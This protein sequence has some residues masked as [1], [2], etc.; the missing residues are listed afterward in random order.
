VYVV[1]VAADAEGVALDVE[2][3]DVFTTPGDNEFQVVP[4]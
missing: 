4:R 1:V 2:T 3:P